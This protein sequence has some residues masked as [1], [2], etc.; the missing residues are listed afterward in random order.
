MS[1]LTSDSKCIHRLDKASLGTCFVL[2]LLISFIA[3]STSQLLVFESFDFR[4]IYFMTHPYEDLSYDTPFPSRYLWVFA[5]I[6]V[7][8]LL[9]LGNAMRRLC[10][11]GALGLIPFSTICFAACGFVYLVIWCVFWAPIV[12]IFYPPAIP[13][14]L[15]EA[16]H[17]A[18]TYGIPLA[19][20]LGFIIELRVPGFWFANKKDTYLAAGLIPATTVV[21]VAWQFFFWSMW[22]RF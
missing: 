18:V 15:M 12:G 4:E 7:T 20:S 9:F 5:P 13:M 2:A 11:K 10:E 6:S 19:V 1:W 16:I 17:V 22:D 14:T 3:G 21:F 8:V